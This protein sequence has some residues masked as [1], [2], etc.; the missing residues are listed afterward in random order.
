MTPL[1]DIYDQL[2]SEY[3]PTRPALQLWYRML[4]CHV[5]ATRPVS[6]FLKSQS[7]ISLPGYDVLTV[8]ARHPDG[9]NMTQLA[10][11]LLV[12]K[13]NV[14][15][16]V[17]GLERSG[18]IVRVVTHADRRGRLVKFTAKGKAF[19]KKTNHRYEAFIGRLLR[20]VDA[21]DRTA[22][23]QQLALMQKRITRSEP[24]VDD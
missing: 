5:H 15:G 1:T 13:S 17:S 10:R 2:C 4:A 22:I 3:A 14:T 9:I 21:A 24:D 12:G 11:L 20:G 8:L 7:H 19:W 18:L 6:R 23:E 16:I